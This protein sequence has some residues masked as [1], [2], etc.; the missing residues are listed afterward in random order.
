MLKKKSLKQH[1]VEVPVTYGFTIH[2]RV[3]D[4]T[5]WFWRCLGTAFVHFLWALTITWSWLG[6]RVVGITN[7]HS[8]HAGPKR[9]RSFYLS[10]HGSWLMCEVALKSI[11]VG[12]LHGKWVS[13]NVRICFDFFRSK[14][15]NFILIFSCLNLKR[16]CMVEIMT[17]KNNPSECQHAITKC[18]HL[19]LARV[20]APNTK[21]VWLHKLTRG[22][23]AYG[24]TIHPFNIKPWTLI[25]VWPLH[26]KWLGL[27]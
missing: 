14:R 3:C 25:G 5:T 4:H 21:V 10:G 26:L 15:F 9:D 1:L 8:I 11:D 6:H 20:S 18:R 19:P 23:F 2:L 12:R 17:I 16:K 13:I 22:N 7:G 24:C 27:D